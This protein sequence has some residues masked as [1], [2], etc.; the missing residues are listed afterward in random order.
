MSEDRYDSM[1]YFVE[2]YLKMPFYADGIAALPQRNLDIEPTCMSDYVSPEDQIVWGTGKRGS[3]QPTDFG[4]EP[5]LRGAV[6]VYDSL[7]TVR[8]FFS[9]CEGEQATLAQALRAAKSNGWTGVTLYDINGK[10]IGEWP[11]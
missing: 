8:K 6:A 5:G 4:M 11:C 3:F 1:R 10:I 2:R 9:D 7:E